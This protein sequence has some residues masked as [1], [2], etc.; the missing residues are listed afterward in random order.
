M[1]LLSLLRTALPG[2]LSSSCLKIFPWKIF[3]IVFLKL[4]HPEKISYNFLKN[5]SHFLGLTSNVFPEKNFFYFFLKKPPWKKFFLFSKKL[6]LTFWDDWWSSRKIKRISWTIGW[7]LIKP[8]IKKS[9]FSKGWLLIFSV[10]KK[11]FKHK[12]ER[13]KFFIFAFMKRQIFLNER[14]FS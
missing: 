5:P 7:L 12:Q 9:Y 1:R 3:L 4:L 8:R 14:A 6:L 11:L 2:A 10:E 13:E